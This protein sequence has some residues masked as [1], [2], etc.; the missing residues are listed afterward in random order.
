MT[1]AWKSLQQESQLAE[2]AELSFSV[3]VIIF[4]HSTSCSIS[5]MALNR[6]ERN[7]EGSVP[8][9]FYFL[10]I[11]SYR[12]VSNLVA[13]KFKVVHESPQLLLIRNGECTYETSH[14]DISF[15]EVKEQLAV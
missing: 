12:N 15:K 7:Y 1:V 13:E 6:F 5:A 11:L 3:P 9:D 4:K 2:I 10:D 8:A 14:T